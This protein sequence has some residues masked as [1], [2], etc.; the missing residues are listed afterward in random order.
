MPGH[1]VWE[2]IDPQSPVHTVRVG[3][4]LVPVRSFLSSPADSCCC[5]AHLGCRSCTAQS[6][7]LTSSSLSSQV[8]LEQIT[9]NSGAYHKQ[10]THINLRFWRSEVQFKSRSHQGWFL[11]EVRGEN[12]FT[13]FCHLLEATCTPQFLELSSLFRASRVGSSVSFADSVL[14]SPPSKN[15]VVTLHPPGYSRL[16]LSISKSLISSNCKVLFCYAR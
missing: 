16:M 13:F 2:T 1:R 8:L 3:A 6:G 12:P 5:W 15:L 7:H 10:H 9:I 14:L 4:V 11:L